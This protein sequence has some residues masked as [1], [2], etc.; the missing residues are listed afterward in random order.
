MKVV[1][2]AKT[3]MGRGACIGALT[4]DGRSL[5]LIA[6]DHETNEQFNQDY[7]VGDVWEI[8][9]IE[10]NEII[11]PHI[12]NVIVL[13]KQY[14]AP[15]TGI[16]D[17]IEAKMPPVY[18]GVDHLFDG[19]S[20]AQNAGARFIARQRG[21]PEFSTMF[22]RPDKTLI[23]D[24][25]QK[26]IR[27][28]YPG[29]DGGS[30]L[31]FVG[32]QEPL[33]EIPAGT[34]VRVSLAHWWRPKEKPEAELRCYLQIS[35][36][37]LETDSIPVQRE[38]CEK[39]HS[40]GHGDR[41]PEI[42]QS[43]QEWFGYSSFRPYQREII[44]R[45]LEKQD[46]LGVMP[47]GSGK[48]LC[49][50]LPAILFPGLTVVVSPLISLMED[51]VLELKE[52]GIVADY[53]NSSMN[54]EQY[55]GVIRRIK[56]RETRLVYA[57]PETLLRP[58]T[59]LLLENALVDCLVI[60][61]AHCISE[62]G[63]DFRPEYR[64]L[65]KLRNRL[66]QAVTLAITATAT[67]RVREDIKQ[68]LQIPDANEFV[69]SFNRENLLLSV[70]DKIN[71]LTQT[72]EFL[73]DHKKQSG[74][75]Y[76]ATRNQVDELTEYLVSLGYPILPYHA[77]MEDETRRENQYR[78]RYED[79]IIIVA[80][81]A[82]GMGI[83]KSNVRFILHYDLPKNLENYYQ[84][85]GRAGRDG[86]PADCLTLFSYRD[87]RVNE[88]FINLEDPKLQPGSKLRLRALTEFLGT[89]GCRRKKLLA[90]F[91]EKYKA[92]NCNACDNCLAPKTDIASIPSDTADGLNEQSLEKINLM[93][94]A[95][96]FLSC[97]K[98]TGE[99]FGVNHLIRVLRGSRAKKVIQ[100]KHDKLECY[101][102]G[103]DTKLEIWRHMAGQFVRLGLVERA[104]PYGNLKL[105][106][107]GESVL[108]GAEVWVE[109]PGRF[110]RDLSSGIQVEYDRLLFDKLRILRS[111]L[112]RSRNVP[113]YVV[114]HDRTLVDMAVFYPETV[115]EFSMISGVGKHKVETYGQQ[116]LKVIRSYC[117]ENNIDLS[118]KNRFRIPKTNSLKGPTR[119][120]IIWKRFQAGE[121]IAT[122][123]ESFGFTQSTILKHLDTVHSSGYPI[124]VDGL[125]EVSV[126][127][128]EEENSVLKLFDELGSYR[129]KPI[130]EKF[131]GSISYEQ[132]HIWR[133]IF[134]V[135][136]PEKRAN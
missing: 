52:L 40:Q 108:N 130:F 19:L 133:L 57:A 107:N 29:K 35:G 135:L 118:Q 42:Q 1:I 18:G 113:P 97:V 36:W 8:D 2:V 100:F 88:Y 96:Q 79:E 75:I 60:D 103:A 121:G 7:Q 22:W 91:G 86:L 63:H 124:R 38:E 47:T 125:R 62:W 15:I 131:A 67:K 98:E 87:I 81:I 32:F 44:E 117:M 37:F 110:A 72:C 28:R 82:F 129:L 90:Y 17:L 89:G 64:Q 55:L 77:G 70:V 101:G 48:S 9:A 21:L 50:Q 16:V 58:E 30:T 84:Q 12:E 43:L 27:Y 23:R 94:P 71:G 66:P 39:D 109:I 104:N 105:T 136:Y 51:Q 126:L 74:I 134:H 116:F 112:A 46:T 4:F 78:F 13:Q 5:R 69:S 93:I 56:A 106:E 80:T 11:P 24:E 102:L 128:K 41:I 31:T 6:V 127:T 65:D 45:I 34:L 132:L 115:D 95:R 119:S 33:S 54:Y 49:F 99:M 3:R 25:D 20:Q 111:K 10:D 53:L 26:R 85:I 61:E 123:A 92:D 76:C 59:I 120:E 122:I 68:S 114:F 73:N 14:L 83:N